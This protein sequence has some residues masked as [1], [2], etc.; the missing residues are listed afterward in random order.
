MIKGK[1]RRFIRAILLV[2][3][4]WLA[5][6]ANQKRP[7]QEC[8]SYFENT[9]N[10]LNVY[11]LYGRFDGNTVFILGGIQ[12]DEPGGF[13]SADLYPNLVLDRGNLI[14]IP[15]ANFHSIIKN[16]RGVN[17][18]MNRRFDNKPPNDIDDQIVDIIQSLMAESDLFINLHDGW[19]FYREK[20]IDK[21]HNPKRFGQSVIAD[22]DVYITGDDTLYLEQMARTVLARVNRRIDNP[23]H[24]MHFM[25]TR[26]LDEDTK[27]PEMKKSATYFALT[28][29]GIPAF[30]IE[31]S[32]NLASLDEKIR[33]HNYAINEFLKLFGVEPEHPAI[34][35]ESPKLIYLLISINDNTPMVVDNNN[36]VKLIR[37][38]QIRITH[39]ES[40]Y[41]R[42]ISCDVL[43]V[44]NDQDF[45]KRLVI[46]SPT[47]IIVRKDNL[48]FGE[49]VLDVSDVDNHLFS[50]IIE[51]NGQK[52][53]LLNGQT[54][55]VKR[56]DQIKI[57]NVLHDQLLPDRYKVNLKG[58]VPPGEY[59]DGE[60]RNY[61]IAVESLRWKKY[62]LNGEGKIYPVIVVNNNKELSR[63]YISIE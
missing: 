26:T 38:D 5:S 44:G 39:I 53:A 12:G 25:N 51:V 11:R 46:N 47:R 29:F 27:F 57:L 54:L 16:S 50:Y 43:G 58:Y 23:D 31:S 49:V 19:G 37:G 2:M 34:I 36:T 52:Q 9:P 41:T 22:A 59:N 21:N 4:P 10:Q 48:I 40:N 60:D 15:R 14:V 7:Y 24:Y 33:Y 35:Y 18:D 17:G 1:N 6:S 20:Y 56:S 30:G 3:L 28:H 8:I 13:L 61:P 32:K 42:G 45:Q 63:I 55:H 62:S